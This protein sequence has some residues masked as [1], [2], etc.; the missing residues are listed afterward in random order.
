M[1]IS[2]MCLPVFRVVNAFASLAPEPFG[3]GIAK[4]D[5]EKRLDA[6]IAV[7]F[8]RHCRRVGFHQVETVG[9]AHDDDARHACPRHCDL[10]PAQCHAAHESGRTPFVAVARFQD[11]HRADRGTG[12][13]RRKPARPLG[14]GADPC[15]RQ[16]RQRRRHDQRRRHGTAAERLA[17]QRQLEDAPAR[18]AVRLGDGKTGPAQRAHLVPEVAVESN[19]VLHDVS[20][21]RDRARPQ[22][23]VATGR[24]KHPLFVRRCEIHDQLERGRPRPRWATT[25]FCTSSV[26]AAMVVGMLRSQ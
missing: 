15:D 8:D 16:R 20:N 4:L 1:A 6:Q 14:V 11:R 10:L 13:E 19:G 3:R 22:H 18:A 9:S 26:P 23:E 17:Q 25:F 2:T 24:R 7:A 5:R 12:G 21:A